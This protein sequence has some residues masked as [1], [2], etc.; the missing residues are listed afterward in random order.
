MKVLFL[1]TANSCRSQMAEAW[2]RHLFPP[3]WQTASAGLMT[4]PISPRTE[5]VMR[6]V[7]LDMEGQRSKSIDEMDLDTF[8][9]VVTLSDEAVRYLPRLRRPARHCPRPFADPMATR[10]S[11]EE[12]RAAFRT[13]R[14]QARAVVCE[15][16]RM[17]HDRSE[18][19][20]VSDDRFDRDK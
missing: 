10:G 2:A 1:C 5:A 7:G 16:L 13:G 4:Y 18:S 19:S 9:L 3:T 6:E 20:A 8:D 15:V 17:F 14:E 11:A 12:L